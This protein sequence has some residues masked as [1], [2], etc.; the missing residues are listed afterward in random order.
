M[1]TYSYSYNNKDRSK[2]AYLFTSVLYFRYVKNLS[3]K[4]LCWKRI[5]EFHYGQYSPYS[6]DIMRETNDNPKIL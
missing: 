2:Y 3:E 5:K 4:Y 6:L 1:V